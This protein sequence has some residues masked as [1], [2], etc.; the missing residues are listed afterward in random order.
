MKKKDLL[1]IDLKSQLEK[2]ELW[3]IKGGQMEITKHST[4]VQG[5]DGML[6]ISDHDTA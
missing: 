3:S 5:P 6:N 4:Y 2:K 1:M